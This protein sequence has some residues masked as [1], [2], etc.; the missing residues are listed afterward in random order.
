MKLGE[1]F[2]DLIVDSSKGELTVSD[3]VTKMGELEVATIGAV[4]ALFQIGAKLAGFTDI[5]IKTALGLEEYATLTGESTD[6]LQRWQ[7]VAAHA[8]VSGEA[9]SKTF[10]GLSSSIAAMNRGGGTGRLQPLID[11]LGIN[12][13]GKSPEQILQFIQHSKRFA[14]LSNKAKTDLLEA[15]G[16]APMLANVFKLSST[17]FEKQGG[18]VEGMS[19]ESVDK[20]SNIAGVLADISSIA[21]Q[22]AMDIA[23]WDAGP[24]LGVLNKIIEAFKAIKEYTKENITQTSDSQ[25]KLFDMAV[26]PISREGRSAWSDLFQYITSG[27][28]VSDNR[29]STP[30][31]QGMVAGYPQSYAGAISSATPAPAA[32]N[33]VTVNHTQNFKVGHDAE[34]IRRAARD[35]A[36]E[37]FDT[38]LSKTG[39]VIDQVSR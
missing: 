33:T 10:M 16:I 38:H 18:L 7:R 32:P 14:A 29:L 26:R 19:K 30:Q 13:S 35:G 36:K 4:G 34:E 20:F 37:V 15:A 28:A 21:K 9:V 23:T 2:I 27:Q 8:N 31:V 5:S 22:I 1:F 25:V 17:E 11:I 6:A 3:L 39:T 24:L 12:P